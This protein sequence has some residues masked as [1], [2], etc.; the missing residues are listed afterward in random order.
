MSSTPLFWRGYLM[1]LHL[2]EDPVLIK[3]HPQIPRSFPIQQIYT[4]TGARGDLSMTGLWSYACLLSE[5]YFQTHI[6][7]SKVLVL[8]ISYSLI[9]PPQPHHMETD[10]N[11]QITTL[12][13]F[14][15][16]DFMNASASNFSKVYILVTAWRNASSS[17]LSCSLVTLVPTEITELQSNLGKEARFKKSAR[18]AQMHRFGANS[19]ERRICFR[20]NKC[21]LTFHT[22]VRRSQ[23]LD[24]VT[25]DWRLKG[26]PRVQNTLSTVN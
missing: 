5:V 18:P 16:A 10:S 6:Y 9:V 14:V 13:Y 26:R 21:R 22:L 2:T 4:P 8:L 11:F 19:T 15:Q 23:L 24:F 7:K 12:C 3:L 25:W 20:E 1:V 17:F